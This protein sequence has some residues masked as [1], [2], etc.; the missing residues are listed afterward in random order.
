MAVRDQA[1]AAFGL[2]ERDRELAL[3]ESVVAGLAGLTGS[4]VLVE[5]AS[6]TGKSRLL[7]VL[8]EFARRADVIVTGT[9]AVDL[10][11]SL[12]FSVVRRLL[13]PPLRSAGRMSRG[14]PRPQWALQALTTRAHRSS[15][16]LAE[17]GMAATHAVVEGVE[18]LV[19]IL[20]PLVVV[21]DDAQWADARSLQLLRYLADRA[22]D[23][24]IVLAVAV[25]RGEVEDGLVAPFRTAG[26]AIVL[27][28]RELSAAGVARV[29]EGQLP[30]AAAAVAAACRRVTGGNPFLLGELLAAVEAAGIAVGPDAGARIQQLAPRTVIDN[31]LVRLARL[32]RDAAALA[33]AIAVLGDGARLRH[34]ARLAGLA[35]ETAAEMADLLVAADILA[36]HDPLAFRH[37]LIAAAVQR[38]LGSFTRTTLH[39]RAADLLAAEGARDRAAAHLLLAA[40]DADPHVVDVLRDAAA[41]AGA[42][43][44]ASTARRFLQRAL[45]EPPQPDLR[46]ELLL[47][48]ARAETAVGDPEA[49]AHTKEAVASIRDQRRAA[50]V[51]RDLSRLH[52]VR[53]EYATAAMVA[54]QALAQTDEDVSD[55]D[56][57][58]A[59]WLLSAGLNPPTIP[60]FSAVTD[61]LMAATRAGSPPRDPEL[62]AIVALMLISSYGDPAEVARLAAAAV[63]GQI[64]VNDDGLG[65]GFGFA[66]S[67][68]LHAGA[69]RS[70]DSA[71]TSALEW[72]DDRGSVVA[73]A[74]AALWRGLA[75]LRLGDLDGAEADAARALVPWRHGWVADAPQAYGL[76]ARVCLERGDR[77]RAREAISAG[78]A[79][80]MPHPPYLFAS[81]LV[82]TAEGDAAGAL[83]DLRRAGELLGSIWR[84]ETPAVLPW[85]SAAARAARHGGMGREAAAFAAAELELARRTGIPSVLA[86]ALRT[87]S[88]VSGG[89]RTIGLLRQALDLV[90]RTDDALETVRTHVELGAAL[91]RAGRRGEARA[92]LGAARDAAA[93]QGLPVLAARAEEEQ[94]A[95][96]GRP[97][98]A[99]VS[100][101]AS[102]TPSERRIAERARAGASNRQIAAELFLTAKTVEWHMGNVFRKLGVSSR[103]ELAAALADTA[104]ATAAAR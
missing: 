43:G 21:V 82:R 24:P 58:R 68:L 48:L 104:E 31:V 35:F 56:R 86:A 102:L 101:P 42:R 75:R 2:I 53:S 26:G 37:P 23:F 13:E 57:L 39:R 91:R 12:P 67:A 10:D 49:L 92:Q 69:L 40:P 80:E 33:R 87:E 34:A 93:R 6:G 9:R 79:V 14:D 74:A 97:R 78:A 3:L 70:L 25:R 94:K 65:L 61:E 4:A 85:R 41:A 66:L 27:E 98:R 88:L 55:R 36:A 8:A 84:V 77:T 73:A 50:S 38:D 51:L 62:Q 96:G 100:G 71:A 90:S 44:D 32:P 72:A 60:A 1:A 99:R 17:G 46:P 64:G 19:D 28:P 18:A 20:G 95:S 30:G 103:L 63:E 47:E 16:P 11:A 54:E 76:L 22:R 29:V 52:H 83:D 81:G 5:G 89:E 7:A 45:E 15:A 59:T